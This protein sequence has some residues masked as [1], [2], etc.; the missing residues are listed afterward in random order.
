MMTIYASFRILI[1]AASLSVSAVCAYASPDGVWRCKASGNIPIALLTISGSNYDMQA[2]SDSNWTLKSGDSS[3]GSGGLD[4]QGNSV[5]PTS[6]PLLDIYGAVGTYCGT[7]D[8][9]C[10]GEALL[11][12]STKNVALGCWRDG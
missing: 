3:S 11:L 2:V 4:I 6:G 8:A 10:S 12:N 1:C 9:G 7:N 5:S